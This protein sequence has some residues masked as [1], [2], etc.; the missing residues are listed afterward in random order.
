ML[1][2]THTHHLPARPVFHTETWNSLEKGGSSSRTLRS[3][4]SRPPADSAL[5]P[6]PWLQGTQTRR[7]LVKHGDKCTGETLCFTGLNV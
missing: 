3:H 7:P 5:H 2:L 6:S 1:K 4:W